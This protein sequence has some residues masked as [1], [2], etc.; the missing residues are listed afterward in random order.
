MHGW[1]LEANQ[2]VGWESQDHHERD[3][4]TDVI[5]VTPS[6]YAEVLGI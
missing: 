3:R 4:V 6:L 1:E 2:G 5:M